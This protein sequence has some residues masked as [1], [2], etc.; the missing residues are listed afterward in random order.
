M[1]QAC[2]LSP[3]LFNL[4]LTEVPSL[5]NK[6]NTDPIILRD[7]LPLNCLLYAD[8]L[9]LIS[10]SASGLQNALTDLSRYCG[11]WLLNI[12]PMKTKIIIFEKKYRTENQQ[13][14]KTVSSF[15]EKRLRL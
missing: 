8:D 15:L 9:V 13:V 3:L 2:I 5:L 14:K 4:Y 6:Q 7:G 1:R 12:N 11:D 10:H